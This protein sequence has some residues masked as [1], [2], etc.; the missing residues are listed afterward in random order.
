M[1]SKITSGVYRC[2]NGFVTAASDKARTVVVPAGALVPYDFGY[3]VM[4]DREHLFD[5]VSQP[6]PSAGGVEQATAA[7]GEQREAKK[8]PAKTAK[9]TAKK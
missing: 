6:R 8:P 7:P 9:S 1:T 2:V 5:D 3:E 4:Q